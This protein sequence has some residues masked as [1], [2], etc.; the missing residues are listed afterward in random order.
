MDKA[1]LR[2]A[3]I[4]IRVG[5]LAGAA[6][7]I[8]FAFVVTIVTIHERSFLRSSGWDAIKRTAVE[9]PSLLALGDLGWL[10]V[11]TFII[12]GVLGI[13]FSSALYRSASSVVGKTCAALLAV[14]SGALALEAFRADSP[15]RTQG[16]SWHASIHN[17]VYPSI[18]VSALGAAV[19]IVVAAG[20][21]RFATRTFRLAT[22]ALLAFM[23]VGIA[24]TW[25]ASVAQ[26]GRY[27]FFGALLIWYELLAITLLHTKPSDLP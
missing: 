6:S 1:R 17:V 2:E 7:P 10:V 11:A 26:F 13:L 22:T 20:R 25:I 16:E 3:R 4:A 27:V 12:C 19:L 18:P 23:V 5:T 21:E 14:M 8:L 9:W 24:L 15:S